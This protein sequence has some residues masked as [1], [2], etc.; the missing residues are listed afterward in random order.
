MSPAPPATLRPRRAVL[1]LAVITV[2]YV[3]ALAW[4]DS[5]NDIMAPLQA[6]ARVAPMLLGLTLVSFG[7]RYLR[8]RW[9]LKRSGAR[10]TPWWKGFAAYLSGFMFT[11]TPGKVGELLRIRYFGRFGVAPE[12]VLAAF[13]HE[14]SFDLLSV[15][16]LA[17]LLLAHHP[18]LFA[19]ALS[20]TALL[21]GA[22]V[23]LMHKP[24]WLRQTA[25]RLHRMSLK[26]LARFAGLLCR[27]LRQCRVWVTP[28]DTL[29]CLALGLL[30]W[31]TVSAAF[32]LLLHSLHLQLPLLQALG[33][34]PLAMLAGA[35]SMLPGGIGSTEATII[36]LLT[37]AGSS[38]ETATLA[39]IGIRLTTLWFSILC[40]MASA[41]LLEI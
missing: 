35:A 27:G 17:T 10:H 9:L 28:A 1:A 13:I 8:W 26:R 39:A 41:L 38:A 14:R 15:L 34:Y 32:T 21:V 7:L 18:R 6:L 12:R 11:A 5:R 37:Q 30:A 33:T 36:V 4:V 31:G 19:V 3:G 25:G 20:F 22:V 2:L 40:G 29:V 16:L 24:A 23:T